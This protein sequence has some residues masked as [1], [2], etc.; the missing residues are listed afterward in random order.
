MRNFIIAAA[1][2]GVASAQLSSLPA[3]GV[4]EASHSIFTLVDKTD[5]MALANLRQQYDWPR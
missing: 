3:C 5:V 2:A 4:S 1:L